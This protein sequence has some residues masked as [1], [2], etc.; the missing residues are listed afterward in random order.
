LPYFKGN[1]RAYL[2]EVLKTNDPDKIEGVLYE[3]MEKMSNV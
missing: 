1:D 3:A 2:V